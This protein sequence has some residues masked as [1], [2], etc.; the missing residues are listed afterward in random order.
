MSLLNPPTVAFILFGITFA[1][2]GMLSTVFAGIGKL[3]HE[4]IGNM[5]LAGVDKRLLRSMRSRVLI[6][7]L[8]WVVSLLLLQVGLVIRL[9]SHNTQ[10]SPDK[11]DG[12]LVR[13]LDPLILLVFLV[14]HVWFWIGQIRVSRLAGSMQ[15][16]APVLAGPEIR[17]LGT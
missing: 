6:W 3:F 1:V 5:E 10:D 13:V 4:N 16:A 2:S 15:S 9:I 7:Q 14:L 12:I 17:R 8:T 11:A